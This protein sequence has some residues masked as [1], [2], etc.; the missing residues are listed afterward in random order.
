MVR[1]LVRITSLVLLCALS[2][3]FVRGVGSSMESPSGKTLDGYQCLPEPCWHGIRPGQTSMAEAETIL[4]QDEN[5]GMDR[6]A[7]SPSERCWYRANGPLWRVCLGPQQHIP[8]IVG[9]VV[10]KFGGPGLATER[11]PLL[12]NALLLFGPP[13]SAT[14]CWYSFAGPVTNPARSMIADF[15]FG[16]GINAEV[17]ELRRPAVVRLDP[18]MPLFLLSYVPPENDHPDEGGWR[19]FT[20]ASDQRTC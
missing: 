17:Y 11:A 13:R 14:L 12:G 20:S 7:L 5:F 18:A 10:L 2:L 4:S 16:S 6:L 3:V 19:G 9:Y 8:G 15:D 1:L